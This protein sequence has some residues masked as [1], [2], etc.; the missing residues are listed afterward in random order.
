MGRV[1]DQ[2][3]EKGVGAE[4]QPGGAEDLAGR[5]GVLELVPAEHNDTLAGLN[6]QVLLH[7]GAHSVDELLIGRDEA[8][9]AQIKAKA[10]IF[11]G[12]G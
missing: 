1:V 10:S 9:T 2:V 6:E 5:E 3:I 7:E 11:G 4:S 8:V 12:A